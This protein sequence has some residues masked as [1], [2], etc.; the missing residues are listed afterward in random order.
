[1]ERQSRIRRALALAL[2]LVALGFAGKALWLQGKAQLAQWLIAQAWEQQLAAGTPVKPWSWA[3]TW[4][5]ARLTTPAGAHHY[6]LAGVS[7]QALAFGP[8]QL[9]NGVAP[10][11]PGTL[12]LAGHQDSH[13]AFLEQLQPGDLLEIQ[14][15]DGREYR[16]RVGSTSVVDSRQ[17]HMLLQHEQAE[18]RLV[19]CF[20]FSSL[21][22]GGPLRYVVS[23]WLEE[24]D[25]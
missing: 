17:Q 9:D 6:A 16:Y 15:S 22:S 4:P 12:L 3:D 10:G 7:G 2:L 23:A 18:L 19:T 13:F 24:E 25:A 8:G 14:G 5:V 1:M 11:R 21:A 20:P